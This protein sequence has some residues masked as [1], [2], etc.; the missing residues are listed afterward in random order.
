MWFLS[1]SK[2][3]DHALPATRGVACVRCAHPFDIP[4]QAIRLTCPACCH[5]A[6]VQDWFVDGY[7]RQR[8]LHTCASVVVRPGATLEAESVA[9]GLVL[10]VH[11]RLLVRT[12]RAGRL[13]VAPG[14]ALAGEF[15]CGSVAIGPAAG[16]DGATLSVGLSPFESPAYAFPGGSIAHVPG[17]GLR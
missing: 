11:G 1:T 13:W 4:A 9:A 6:S 5:R 16:L 2:P 7:E 12:A 15:V 17:A 10:E 3:A 8:Q 14:A